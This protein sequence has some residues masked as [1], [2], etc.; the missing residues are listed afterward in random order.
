MVFM[1]DLASLALL[2]SAIMVLVVGFPYWSVR[3]LYLP[4]IQGRD[5]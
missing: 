3:W 4:L 2:H 1:F 5:P